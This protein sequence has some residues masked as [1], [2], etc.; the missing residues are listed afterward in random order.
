M[1]C[2]KNFA[3]HKGL[4]H[5]LKTFVIS[6]KIDLGLALHVKTIDFFCT[7]WSFAFLHKSNEKLQ[8]SIVCS[9]EVT[10]L[11][12]YISS[13]NFWYFHYSLSRYLVIAPLIKI[14]Q[15]LSSLTTGVEK[16][17]AQ[18]MSTKAAKK[19]VERSSLSYFLA[20]VS[21]SRKRPLLQRKPLAIALH[22][23]FP[24]RQISLFP[25]QTLVIFLELLYIYNNL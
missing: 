2:L 18:G 4:E 9:R 14:N 1:K 10:L 15:L 19:K 3:T 22:L 24:W 7:Y 11:V 8:F 20:G 12:T 16:P 6:I 25:F 17:T 5:L 23:V 21:S 13:Q